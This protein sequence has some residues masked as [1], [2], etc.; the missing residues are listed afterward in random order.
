MASGILTVPT[1]HLPKVIKTIRTGMKRLLMD[2]DLKMTDVV[3]IELTQWCSDMEAY[4]VRLKDKDNGGQT[5][6]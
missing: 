4:L 5:V 1:P 2:G 6:Q 3:Y